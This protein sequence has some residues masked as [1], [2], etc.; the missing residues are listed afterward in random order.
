ML[1]VTEE[2]GLLTAERFL[3]AC[4]LSDGNRNLA[5]DILTSNRLRP[6]TSTPSPTPSP[7]ATSPATN[8]AVPTA[9]PSNPPT[10]IPSPT[11]TILPPP[12]PTPTA[13]PPPRPLY[14]PLA[15]RERCRPDE[16]RLDIALVLDASTS[17]LE[18]TAAGRTKL[19]AA[20]EA[21]RILLDQLR[22]DKGD[23]AALIAFNADVTTLQTLTSVRAD[24][25]GALMRIAVAQQTRIDLGVQAAADEFGS[26]RHRPSH[27]PVMVVLTDGRANPV[28]ADVAVANAA[29]AKAAGITVYTV[30]VGADLDLEALRAMA[31]SPAHVF[32]APDAEQLADVYRA[33]A[34]ALPCAGR[35]WPGGGTGP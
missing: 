24:L 13:S 11:A 30:G 17:M 35:Y 31:S 12:S 33:I 14:L 22:L 9:S 32:L 18:P 3:T 19:E 8:T 4:P 7:T 5:N 2:G 26:A 21:A 15:L 10:S 1:S 27:T 20:T 25:D 29:A 23:Q 16:Q 34:V 6:P 28:P